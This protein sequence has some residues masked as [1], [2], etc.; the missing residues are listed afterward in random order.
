MYVSTRLGRW[1][2]EVRGTQLRA[3]DATIVLWHSFLCDGGMWDGQVEALAALGR[4]VVFDGPGHGKSEP[5]PKFTLDDNTRALEDALDVV[6][7]GPVVLAGL[8]WGGML[9]MRLAL[10]DPGR[11][12]ALVLIDTNAD[13]EERR[14]QLKYRAMLAIY[15]RA[16]V[17]RWLVDKQVAPIMFGKKTVRERPAIVDAFYRD[18]NGYSRAGVMTAAKAIFWRE[19]IVPRLGNVRAPSLVLCGRDDAATP[20]ARSETIA[21][22]IPGARLE[23]I[24]DAGHLSAL[25][26]PA[27]VRDAMVPF[28]RDHLGV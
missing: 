24:S 2:Y 14:R 7:P 13:P 12:R 1:F 27:A 19:D 26:E 25:E 4:V 21:R 22:A 6:A 23:L 17:P 28:V 15:E 8:S 11:V 3:S 20:V 5:A 16:G 9:G 18:V 10:L